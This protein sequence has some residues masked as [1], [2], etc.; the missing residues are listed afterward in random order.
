MRIRREA[1][2]YR[3]LEEQ[4]AQFEHRHGMSSAEFVEKFRSDQI[5]ETIDFCEWERVYSILEQYQERRATAV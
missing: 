4:L 5:A 1:A 2:S 3:L